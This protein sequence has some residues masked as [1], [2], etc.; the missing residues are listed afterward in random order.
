MLMIITFQSSLDTSAVIKTSHLWALR[1][2]FSRTWVCGWNL[3]SLN[4]EDYLVLNRGDPG[5]GREFLSCLKVNRIGRSVPWV[6]KYAA[7]AFLDNYWRQSC[8]LTNNDKKN[9]HA[10]NNHEKCY[11][12]YIYLLLF[13][14]K[15]SFKTRFSIYSIFQVKHTL[16]SFHVHFHSILFCSH[17]FW[18]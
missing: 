15:G 7:L 1:A 14:L 5:E 2:C 10:N 4:G 17:L 11:I 6:L 18:L 3:F 8:F 9:F 13:F 12:G 16:F